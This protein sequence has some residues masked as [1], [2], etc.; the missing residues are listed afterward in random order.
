MYIVGIDPG[1]VYTN[2]EAVNKG[3]CP[4]AGTLGT[5]ANGNV[6]KMVEVTTAQN[7]TEGLVVTISSSHKATVA[8]TVQPGTAI[9]ELGI[10]RATATA[11]ASSFIWAQVYGRGTVAVSSAS[12]LPNVVLVMGITPGMVDDGTPTSASAFIDGLT[13]TATS[14]VAGALT[15]AIINWPMFSGQ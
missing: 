14:D 3:K 7:L 13:L 5:T 4:V 12:A 10:V 2:D 15:A 8:A 1:R 6:Y 9:R 11:S